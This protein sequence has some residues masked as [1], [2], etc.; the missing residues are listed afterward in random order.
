MNLLEINRIKSIGLKWKILIPF[1]CFA[2]AG[3]IILSYIG[4]TSQQRLIKMEEKEGM[5]H[6]YGLLLEEVNHKETEALSLATLGS[7]LKG[8]DRP[9]MI[10]WSRPMSR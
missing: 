1:L 3:T 10:C 9:L 5:T 4:L 8:I 6:F 2:F 7:W